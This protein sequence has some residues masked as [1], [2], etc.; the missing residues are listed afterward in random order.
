MKRLRRGPRKA[1]PLTLSLRAK[2]W[3]PWP[4]GLRGLYVPIWGWEKGK[5]ETT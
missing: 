1:T 3:K 4:G 2:G 5:G